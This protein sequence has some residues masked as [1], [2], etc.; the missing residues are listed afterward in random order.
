MDEYQDSYEQAEKD[1]NLHVAHMIERMEW[2]NTL[3]PS[4]YHKRRLIRFIQGLPQ[5]AEAA[6]TENM[7]WLL[8]GHLERMCHH[9]EMALG[10]DWREQARKERI[11]FFNEDE[12]E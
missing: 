10:M 12:S 4:E 9:A 7:P 2:E 3:P 5:A 6:A 11:A 8:F 1:L